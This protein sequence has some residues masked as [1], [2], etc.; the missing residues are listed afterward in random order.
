[1][2]PMESTKADHTVLKA[3][4]AAALADGPMPV[5]QLHQRAVAAGLLTAGEAPLWRKKP[6]RRVAARLGVKHEQR[7]REWVWRLISPKHSQVPLQVPAISDALQPNTQMPIEAI[8]AALRSFLSERRR[9]NG[10]PSQLLEALRAENKDWPANPKA[11][12]AALRSSA[13]QLRNAGITITF[14]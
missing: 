9:W 2:L 5:R 4:L 14:G 7:E 13:E 11:F 8:A 12:C 1:M 10:K 6:W 3:F